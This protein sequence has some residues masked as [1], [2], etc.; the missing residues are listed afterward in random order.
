MAQLIVRNLDEELVRQ[1][2]VRAARRGRSAEAE[3][4][5]ILREALT[6]RKT[7]KTLKQRL[8]EMPAVGEDAD[9][10]R[11]RD[12]GRRTRL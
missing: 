7:R 12:L 6:A 1:L 3:H 11:P 2:K 8:L 5:E 9:F 10:E 4:R